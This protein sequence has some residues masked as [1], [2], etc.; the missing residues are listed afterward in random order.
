MEES[1]EMALETKSSRP[2]SLTNREHDVLKLILNEHTTQE[3]AEFLQLSPHTVETHR[4]NLLVK[5]GSRNTAGLV[6]YAISHN[7]LT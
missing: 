6:R 2:A 7:L 4:K 5:T 3:I 1:P